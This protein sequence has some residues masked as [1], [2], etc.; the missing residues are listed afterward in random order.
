MASD[1][2]P[3]GRNLTLARARKVDRTGG[4]FFVCVSDYTNRI[5]AR[6]S[7]GKAEKR[8]NHKRAWMKRCFLFVC[9]FVELPLVN[10]P[11]SGCFKPKRGYA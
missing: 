3:T 4:L 1:P 2:R 10:Q 6:G 8:I 11:V 9:L 5:D 7:M